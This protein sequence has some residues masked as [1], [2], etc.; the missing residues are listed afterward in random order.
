[1]AI[2]IN[3]CHRNGEAEAVLLQFPSGEMLARPVSTRVNSARNDD[4]ELIQSIDLASAEDVT[5]DLF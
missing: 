1:M 2:D 5:Q 3:N 4:P